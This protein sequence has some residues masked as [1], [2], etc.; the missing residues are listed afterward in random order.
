MITNG[1]IPEQACT[2]I[3][4]YE[5]ISLISD[6]ML[7]AAT[8]DKWDAVFLL[9][10]QYSESV[11]TLK[12]LSNVNLPPMIQ[13]EKKRQRELL[14]HILE[15]DASVRDL[16]SPEYMRVGKLLRQFRRQNA[17][18]ATYSQKHVTPYTT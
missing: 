7:E 11:G 13:S 4:I 1:P 16:A 14:T 6:G 15:N 5:R 9:S 12:C 17:V 2:V 10:E 18:L 8:E 3:E